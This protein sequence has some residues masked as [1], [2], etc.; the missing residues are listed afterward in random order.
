MQ[1]LGAG[2]TYSS[3]LDYCST[4]KAGI[5]RA[6]FFPAKESGLKGQIFRIHKFRTML[7]IQSV[8]V[9]K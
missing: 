3:F 1:W 7:N 2:I 9:C 5:E 8:V 6:N 4:Y